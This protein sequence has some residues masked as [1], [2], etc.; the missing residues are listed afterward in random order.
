MLMVALVDNDAYNGK[1]AKNPFNFKNYNLINCQEQEC[2][3]ESHDE[4][5]SSLTPW[6]IFKTK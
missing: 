6:C 5:E 1:I 2:V 4:G 3:N